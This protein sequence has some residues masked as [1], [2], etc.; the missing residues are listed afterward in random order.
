MA[1]FGSGHQKQSFST[2]DDPK[3]FLLVT[4]MKNYHAF[5][6]DIVNIL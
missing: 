1:N 2:D 4:L 6:S 3:K 5:S